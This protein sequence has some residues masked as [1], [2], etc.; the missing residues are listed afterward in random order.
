VLD[1]E[2]DDADISGL[3]GHDESDPKER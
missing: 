1:E 3:V 2:P